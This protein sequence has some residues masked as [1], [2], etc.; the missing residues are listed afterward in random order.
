MPSIS[1]AHSRRPTEAI[2]LGHDHGI[3][4]LER[5]HQLG[6]PPHRADP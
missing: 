5:G 6:D 2:E 3:A 1:L 4:G